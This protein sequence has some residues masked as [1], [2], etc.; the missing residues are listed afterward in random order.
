MLN[1]NQHETFHFRH[2]AP[3]TRL[4]EKLLLLNR[5]SLLRALLHVTFVIMLT[6]ALRVAVYRSSYPG[7]LY[8]FYSVPEATSPMCSF[9]SPLCFLYHLE[10]GPTYY[11]ISQ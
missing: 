2:F 1:G 10:N 8:V 7:I 11:K 5:F 9:I 3:V 6:A 4:D